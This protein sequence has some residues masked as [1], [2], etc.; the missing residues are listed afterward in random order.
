MDQYGRD[1]R[2]YIRFRESDSFERR[3]DS[4]DGSF[5]Q[6]DRE[7]RRP[8]LGRN[9]GINR[10]GEERIRHDSYQDDQ[11]RPGYDPTYE[12]EYGMK[13]PYEHGGESNRWSD[14]IRSEASRESYRGKG[15]KGYKRS[16][17][18]IREE[19]CEI[20]TRS[21]DLDASNI[22]VV[23]QDDI[24]VLDG[25]VSSRHD[26]RLAEDLV[27]NISG[28]R[29]VHN[30]LVIQKNDVEGWIPGVGHVK[31][32]ERGANGKAK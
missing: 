29:D 19:A 4:S 15:P 17:E 26:K 24:L 8:P 28:V 23:I 21:H 9:P 2:D 18:R 27:E 30:H 10:F 22:D 16:S 12:D 14:D 6:Q 25:E 13:H 1:Q 7:Q 3:Q 31:S 20:L 11:Y 32:D 5:T